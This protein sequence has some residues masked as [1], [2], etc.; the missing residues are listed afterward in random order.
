VGVY[1]LPLCCNRKKNQTG[2]A[3]NTERSFDSMNAFCKKTPYRVCPYCGAHL[4]AGETCDCRRQE[5]QNQTAAE[6]A[7]KT[8]AG[9]DRA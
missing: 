6:R 3:V 8:V 7:A 9:G 4:D 5:Q 1:F 2:T